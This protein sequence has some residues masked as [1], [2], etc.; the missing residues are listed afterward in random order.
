[1]GGNALDLSPD[2]EPRAF[3][4][5]STTVMMMLVLVLDVFCH[6]IRRR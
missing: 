5:V 6:E 1:M 2:P 4:A 3:C